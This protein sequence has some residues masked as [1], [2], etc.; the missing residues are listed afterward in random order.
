MAHCV[1]NVGHH[2]V[3]LFLLLLTLN[4]LQ[5]LHKLRILCIHSQY[6]SGSTLQQVVMSANERVLL[7]AEGGEL[8]RSVCCHSVTHGDTQDHVL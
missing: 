1:V 2:F 5:P 3:V 8:A 6:I 7:L 4:L